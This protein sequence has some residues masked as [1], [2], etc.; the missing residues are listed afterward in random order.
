MYIVLLSGGSGK[1]LWPLSNE[2]RSKQFIKIFG[3][4]NSGRESMAQR[5]YRGIT[6]AIPDASV[7]ISTGRM[8]AAGLISQLG[9]GINLCVEPARKDTF[10]AIVL[11]ANYLKHE[12]GANREEAVVVCPIDPYVDEDY[13]LMLKRLGEHA[14]SGNDNLCLMGIKPTYPSE[15]YG[16]IV[17]D[18]SGKVKRFK[19]KPGLEEARKLVKEGA[20]WNGGVFS[21]KLGYL[22]D[23]SHRLIDYCDYTDLLEKYGT[24]EKI[25]FDY[26]V[27]ENEKNICVLDFCGKWKD[28]GTWNTLS[29]AMDSDAIGNVIM[30]E[31]CENTHVIN[32]TDVP[33]LA[34]GLKNVIVAVS[35]DGIL[36]SDKAQSSYMKQYVDKIEGPVMYAEKLWGS[37]RVLDIGKNGMVIK[38]TLN[39]GHSMNYHSHNFRDEVWTV[40]EGEGQV[41][42]D[43]KLFNVYP[44]DTVRLPKGSKHTVKAITTLVISEAQIGNTDAADKVIYKEND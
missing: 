4:G 31:T 10:P 13:F 43:G 35:P 44:G 32:E 40:L 5:M 21:F 27:S 37:Y 12:L 39:P 17:A 15:K 18:S 36:V 24:L 16:Y 6:S 20:L 19:E 3:N 23:I 2:V 41:T 25:S 42:L 8:Q 30:D 22:L 26:A 28:L 14:E 1:R 29:E 38:V 11:A 34:M 33:V 7:V 9:E